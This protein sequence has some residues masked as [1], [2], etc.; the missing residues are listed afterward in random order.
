[1][2]GRRPGLQ[3]R[4]ATIRRTPTPMRIPPTTAKAGPLLVPRRAIFPVS[5][6][7]RNTIPIIMEMTPRMGGKVSAEMGRVKMISLSPQL[8]A[9]APK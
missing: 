3:P 8:A 7:T 6:P 9:A 2:I 1:M 4:L 5:P